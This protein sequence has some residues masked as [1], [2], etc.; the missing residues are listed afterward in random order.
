[1]LDAEISD[2][3]LPERRIHQE[4]VQQH[5]HRPIAAGVL[6][7]DR[8]GRELDLFHGHTPRR[9]YHHGKQMV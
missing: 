1:V 5:D 6:I 2:H 3:S 4:P 9:R 8:P 7:F